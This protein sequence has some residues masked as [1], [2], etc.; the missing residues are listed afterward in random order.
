MYSYTLTNGGC[1]T[2]N[3]VN[4]VVNPNQSITINGS[5]NVCANKQSSLSATG[6]NTFT[7][8]TGAFT[9]SV[10]VSSSVATVYTVSG[11]NQF[12]CLCTKQITVN[13]KP[14]PTLSLVGT[15]TVCV[16]DSI[17]L[18]ASSNAAD[19]YWCTGDNTTTLAITPTTT[20]TY[21]ILVTYTNGCSVADSIKI[22]VNPCTG[23]KGIEA[24]L[25]G[26]LA[27]PNPFKDKLIFECDLKKDD[28][29]KLKMYDVF[30]RSVK[31]EYF[32]FVSGKNKKEFQFND[33]ANG[34]Y[35]LIIQKDN[36]VFKTRLIKE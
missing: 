6:I 8:S 11:L 28:A 21:S 36:E 15:L 31:E 32:N 33:L 18:T 34:V 5:T 29:Y 20:T 27:Y 17:A 12:G 22:T 16:G 3:F 14:T 26:G 25:T 13:I 2:N 9:S 19:Y 24:N 1:V 10:I 30:G 23:V 4:V 7:W 35:M